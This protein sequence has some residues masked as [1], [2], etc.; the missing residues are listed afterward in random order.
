MFSSSRCWSCGGRPPARGT[1]GSRPGVSLRRPPRR[2]PMPAEDRKFERHSGRYTPVGYTH[3]E[4]ARQA[5]GTR[6]TLRLRPKRGV[7]LELR[8]RPCSRVRVNPPVV[9]ADGWP[10]RPGRAKQTR[11]DRQRGRGALD[12]RP[13]AHTLSTVW[14][15]PA[16]NSLWRPRLASRFTNR[17]D[18]RASRSA[19]VE[20]GTLGTT[21]ARQAALPA[22]PPAWRSGLARKGGVGG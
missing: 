20:L 17:S 7:L 9:A 11:R 21:P 3:P 19:S 4:L 10:R 8:P 14:T 6:K 22:R 1:C 15:F 12:D 18:A 13:E 2:A 16:V 5:L